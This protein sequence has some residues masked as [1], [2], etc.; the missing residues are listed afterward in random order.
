MI[1]LRNRV[2]ARSRLAERLAVA[3]AARLRHQVIRLQRSAAMDMARDGRF[4]G[5][6]AS[7]DQRLT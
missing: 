6:G 1:E 3:R 2:E 4:G 5:P 7:P